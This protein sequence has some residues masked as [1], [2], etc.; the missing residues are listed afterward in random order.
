MFEASLM[1]IYCFSVSYKES[2]K[3]NITSLTTYNQ[4][5]GFTDL[6]KFSSSGGS[7]TEHSAIELII[8]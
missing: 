4:E 2:L 7:K 8:K 3:H 1:K 6:E 5:R